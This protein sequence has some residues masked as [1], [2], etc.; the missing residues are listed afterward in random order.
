MGKLE[1]L[2]LSVDPGWSRTKKREL[3]AQRQGCKVHIVDSLMAAYSFTEEQAPTVAIVENGFAGLPEFQTMETLFAALNVKCIL[4]GD[5]V[6]SRS[7][8]G[9]IRL[10]KSDPTATYL[11][12]FG[13]S[14]P[15]EG[16]P[17]TRTDGTGRKSARA[18]RKVIL[19]GSST[20]G[21][22]A[23][24]TILKSFP[25]DCPPTVIVQHTGED[26]GRGLIDILSRSCPARVRPAEPGVTLER[27]L[28]CVAAGRRRHLELRPGRPPSTQMSEG[29]L[30]SGHIPSVDKLFTS[31]VPIAKD[32]V[33]TLLTGMG[34][35]GANGLLELRKAGAT[36]FAQDEGSSVV[37]GMPRAA[38]QIGAA[39]KQVSLDRMAHALLGASTV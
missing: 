31:A 19:I 33:A 16:A 39:Q 7:K 3:E 18:S 34:R 23:L 12:V 13:R 17:A 22:D 11:A 29:S 21:V 15:A 6:S 4:V 5:Q 1:I 24:R 20:G 10:R 9:M 38:W 8:P 27:G 35:D 2:I 26:F 32:I 30:V 37:Y 25:S 28:I 14:V 36:T